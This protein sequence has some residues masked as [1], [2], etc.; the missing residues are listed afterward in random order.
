LA[1]T[2]GNPAVFLIWNANLYI[3]FKVSKMNTE[4]K[5]NP[6]LCLALP[7][8][9]GNYTK[10][11][12]ELMKAVSETVPV[13]YIDYAF[14][15]KDVVMALLG[16]K[17]GLPIKKVLGLGSRLRK[18]GT[19]LMVWSLPPLLPING[20]PKGGVFDA[21]HRIN[22]QIVHQS[23]RRAVKAWGQQKF[24]AINACQ[25]LYAKAMQSIGAE[26]LLY[27]CYDEI[28]AANWTERH[29][30]RFEAEALKTADGLIC[31]G[32]Q[33]LAQ[34]RQPDQP[35][36]QIPNGVDAIFLNV[37]RAVAPV[38]RPV[39]GYVG[40]LDERIDL[41][42]VEEVVKSMLECDFSFTGRVQD[43]AISNRLSRYTNVHFNAPIAYHALP[44]RMRHFSVGIIPFLRNELTNG[45]YPM[46]VNEYLALG[47]PVVSTSFGD[48]PQLA[49]WANL[50][51]DSRS[52][53]AALREVI[54]IDNAEKM[55]QRKAFA[56]NQTWQARAQQLL[57]FVGY[58]SEKN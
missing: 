9:E 18:P 6:I 33:L 40:S 15:W 29:V 34:K 41:D 58:T 1:E 20:L 37:E 35:G 31:S 36:V 49:S 7:A 3:F 17:P 10:S 32:S 48:M 46:K 24:A 21:L 26:C 13:L 19:N 50:A 16:K 2:H 5:Q 57:D 53:V 12:V 11:T 42:L 39:I 52:F 45:I 55:M 43:E 25:P 22:E 54:S 8:W 47:L 27:Y 23:L 56:S 44:E 30:A 4:F 28:G 38:D 51:N 14:T